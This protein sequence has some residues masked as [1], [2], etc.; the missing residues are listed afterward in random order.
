MVVPSFS[1][2]LRWEKNIFHQ[3]QNNG[4]VFGCGIVDG[5]CFFTKNGLFTGTALRV[6]PQKL[7]PTVGF[8]GRLG[9]SSV[10]GNFGQEKFK[11]DLDWEKVRKLCGPTVWYS[12]PGT[13]DP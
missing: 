13:A 5:K 2:Q 10:E 1:R 11:F 6:A 12:D 3:L 8:N 7:Y 4:D 9:G